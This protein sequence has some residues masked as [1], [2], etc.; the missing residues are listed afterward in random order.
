MT[1]DAPRNPA[2]PREQVHAWVEDIDRNKKG[3]KPALQFLLSKQRPL[4]RYVHDGV[5]NAG[6]ERRSTVMFITGVLMRI[7]DLAGGKL[8]KVGVKDLKA[9]EDRIAALAP[10]VLPPDEGFGDRIREIG[11]RA[12]PHIL[13]ECLIDLFDNP[14]LDR[15]QSTKLYLLAWIVVEALDACWTPPDGFEGE[16]PTEPGYVDPYAAAED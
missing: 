14:E 15:V 1:T 7:F 6:I 3:H 11:D 2:I 10:Q 8:T 4:T 5:A 16:P 13:D 9:A 12:Q